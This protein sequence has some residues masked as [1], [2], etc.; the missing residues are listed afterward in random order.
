MGMHRNTENSALTQDFI[1]YSTFRKSARTSHPWRGQHHPCKYSEPTWAWSWA[2]CCG[3]CCWIGQLDCVVSGG[4]YQ[5]QLFCNV[6]KNTVK[7]NDAKTSPG[8]SAPLCKPI[9]CLASPA[10]VQAQSKSQQGPKPYWDEKK[11]EDG[12]GHIQAAGT[13]DLPC[14]LSSCPSSKAAQWAV[15]GRLS[16][17][18]PA[19][20]WN[21]QPAGNF[22]SSASQELQNPL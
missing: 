3:W 18:C 20:G 9:H 17:L 5:P 21:G 11:E 16:H 2:S 22:L 13:E 4:A 7:S 6:H 10:S 15:E 12:C 1:L 19:G 8:T 14:P